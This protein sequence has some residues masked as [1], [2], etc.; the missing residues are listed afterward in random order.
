MTPSTIIPSVP[1]AASSPNSI[2]QAPIAL[3]AL[4]HVCLLSR[5]CSGLL[6]AVEPIISGIPC[7]GEHK[8]TYYRV[9]IHESQYISIYFFPCLS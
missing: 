4:V 7:P 5:Y 9:P 2:L 8:P 3:P 6:W 1:T